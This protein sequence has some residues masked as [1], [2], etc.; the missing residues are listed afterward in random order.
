MFFDGIFFRLFEEFVGFKVFIW[1]CMFIRYNKCCCNFS[2]RYWIREIFLKLGLYCN[3]IFV[4]V[5]YF[6]IVGYF[7]VVF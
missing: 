4:V 5:I 6:V 1:F 2:V 3:F 7:K